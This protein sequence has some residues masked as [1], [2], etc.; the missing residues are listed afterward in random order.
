MASLSLRW[1]FGNRKLVKTRTVS[2][3]L[4]AFRSR[5]NFVVCPGA[6]W[7]AIP[8]YARQARYMFPDAVRAREHNLAIVRESLPLFERFAVS[9]LEQLARVDSVRVHDSGDFFSQ[10]YLDAWFRIMRRFERKRFYAY[11]K[12]LHLDWLRQ[13]LNFQLVQSFGG[14]FDAKI[15]RA[16]SHTRIFATHRDRI[17]AGYCNGNT[18]DKPAQ[19]GALKIGLVYHGSTK[20]TEQKV[21]WL[22]D[23]SAT[24]DTSGG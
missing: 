12:S 10:E 18:N 21:I 9:D 14:K 20:L 16:A 23:K 2:F 8:C 15:N 19:K 5:D 17:A 1:S 7:C 22:R 13:P 24:A 4:P 6:E 11:S 3:N